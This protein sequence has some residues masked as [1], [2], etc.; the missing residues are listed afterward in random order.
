MAIATCLLLASVLTFLR[1]KTGI[2]PWKPATALL[3]KGVF[4]YSR[5]PIYLG[6]CFLVSGI[7]L[8]LNTVWLL[9]SLFPSVWLLMRWVISKEERYLEQRFGEHYL[10]YKQRVRRWL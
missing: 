6:F 2:E 9:L 5:N 1:H 8:Y 3:T 4:A 7:A 10:C